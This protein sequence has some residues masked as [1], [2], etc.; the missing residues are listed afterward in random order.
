MV[1]VN[2]GRIQFQGRHGHPLTIVVGA[3]HQLDVRV[4][5]QDVGA[6]AGPGGQEGQALRGGVCIDVDND[7]LVDI[8][9]EVPAL[10]AG[11]VVNA[12]AALDG[13]GDFYDNWVG[14]IDVYATPLD[15]AAFYSNLETMQ[16]SGEINQ[17]VKR[18][19]VIYVDYRCHFCHGEEAVH[20]CIF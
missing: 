15:I 5:L 3:V 11:S 7:T 12:F 18:G 20:I 13:A 19:E 16:G 17:E 6:E 4:E 9:V 1:H 10:A 2:Q 14:S 8:F